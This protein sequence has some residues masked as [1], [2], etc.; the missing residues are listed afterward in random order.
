MSEHKRKLE[1]SHKRLKKDALARSHFKNGLFCSFNWQKFRTLSEPS[2]TEVSEKHA[3]SCTIGGSRCRYHLSEEWFGNMYQNV[4]VS[5]H[6]A[7]KS[8]FQCHFP[9][10]VHRYAKVPGHSCTAL[11]TIA[12]QNLLHKS[13]HVCHIYQ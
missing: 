11:F 12:K 6:L 4:K 5:C 10:M 8:N 2:E 13:L 7:Y 1:M 9:R 3:C